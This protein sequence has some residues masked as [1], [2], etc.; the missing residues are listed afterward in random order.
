MTPTLPISSPSAGGQ[1]AGA[2]Q[3]SELSLTPE[4]TK[5]GQASLWALVPTLTPTPASTTFPT[6]TIAGQEASLY[7]SPDLNSPIVGAL[8]PGEALTVAGIHTTGAWY[9]LEDGSW[10]RV[11][12]VANP[13]AQLPLVA[14]TI[15]PRPTATPLPTPTETPT[16]TQTPAATSTPAPTSLSVVVCDCSEDKYHC[17]ASDFPTRANAQACYEYCFRITGRDIHFL[18]PNRNGRACEQLP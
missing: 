11:E 15:T 12:A 10:I 13:P 18:D 3:T 1:E 17:Q 8:S 7:L 5:T 9:L 6:Q 2:V 4:I 16:P 14:P